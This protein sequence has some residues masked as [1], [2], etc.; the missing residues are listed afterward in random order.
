MSGWY[1]VT[2]EQE[3]YA[4]EY[5][6]SAVLDELLQ[7]KDN[8][9]MDT[10]YLALFTDETPQDEYG[11]AVE[12]PTNSVFGWTGYSRAA[13]NKS[14]WDAITEGSTYYNSEILFYSNKTL[15]WGNIRYYGIFDSPTG[16]NLLYYHQFSYDRYVDT[17]TKLTIAAGEINIRLGCNCSHYLAT[18]ILERT[19]GIDSGTWPTA[20]YCAIFSELPA[21][22]GTGGHENNE[23]ASYS[24]QLICS[25][26]LKQWTDAS[27]G[28]TE[29]LYDITFGTF[30]EEN[31]YIVGVGLYD[32]DTEGNLLLIGECFEET[33]KYYTD[34]YTIPAGDLRVYFD[35]PPVEP[36]S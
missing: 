3:N 30:Y 13:F 34:T 11:S 36:H 18:L 24:R 20:I 16:G 6:K 35:L 2:T 22:D 9:K 5:L 29:T 25:G 33:T 27:L 15:A 4:S 21:L 10:V 14:N 32:D 12:V 28:Q 8:L 17:D 23:D 26:A 1:K 7:F 31:V 19:L